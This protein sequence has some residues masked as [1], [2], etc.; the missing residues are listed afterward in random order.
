[1]N[2]GAVCGR[3]QTLVTSKNWDQREAF[4]E[5]LRVAIRDET[6]ANGTYYP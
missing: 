6:F 2:G 1:M 4:L 3:T 5:A